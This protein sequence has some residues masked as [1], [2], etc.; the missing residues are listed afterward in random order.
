MKNRFWGKRVL[1][2]LAT[3][4]LALPL[5]AGCTASEAKDTEQ[6]VLR[7]ATLWEARM[8]A[9]SVSNLQMHLN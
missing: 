7:V 8:T 9:I 5:I 2:V 3:A 4:S 1:A 6:R